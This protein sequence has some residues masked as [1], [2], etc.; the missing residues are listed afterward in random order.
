MAGSL[1]GIAVL[2]NTGG[3]AMAFEGNGGTVN[4][5]L[6][7][8]SKKQSKRT[9]LTWSINALVIGQGHE[10]N[11]L[12]TSGAFDRVHNTHHPLLA[13]GRHVYCFFFFFFSFSQ[14]QSL[15][16]SLEE[17]SLAGNVLRKT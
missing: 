11:G 6:T 4:G 2:L 14:V 12:P 13:A 7:L 9:E 17:P 8:M 10:I 15:D 1:K 3:G 5:R 16:M